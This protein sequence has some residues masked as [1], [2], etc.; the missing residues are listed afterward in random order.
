MLTESEIDTQVVIPDRAA[1]ISAMLVPNL[2]GGKNMQ[3]N[4]A[5]APV[6]TREVRACDLETGD[7]VVFSDDGTVKTAQAWL[8]TGEG[9]F[10]SVIGTVQG[11][12]GQALLES[13]LSKHSFFILRPAQA[14]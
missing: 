9:K 3:T 2:Y 12:K 11:P 4:K 10:A 7:V 5:F 14:I 13:L 8:C 6:R 1:G